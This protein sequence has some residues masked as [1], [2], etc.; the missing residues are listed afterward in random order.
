[1]TRA[2]TWHVTGVVTFALFMDYMIFGLV[3]PLTLYSPAQITDEEQ[4]ALLYGAYALGT[5]AA[6]PL[7]GYLGSRIGLRRTMICGVALS[8]AATMGFWLAPD[9]A[10]LFVAR[11]LQGG[12]AAATWTAGLSLIAAYHVE[13]RVEM[14]GYAL[15][16]STAGSVLGPVAGGLLYEAGG[17]SLP[18]LLTI[19]LVA[20]DAVL[21]V[22]VLPADRGSPESDRKSVV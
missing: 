18:F 1:M 13:R 5:L 15:M 4:F 10:L 22:F 3:V 14:M 6:T 20:V 19:V 2:R 16:G 17:Y 11:L 9:F 8:A 12:A 21:R 7:F